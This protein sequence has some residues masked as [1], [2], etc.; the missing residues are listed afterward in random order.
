MSKEQGRYE[1][2][3]AWPIITAIMQ[4]RKIRGKVVVRFEKKE[5]KKEGDSETRGAASFSQQGGGKKLGV[6]Y[7]V[8]EYGECIVDMLSNV[9]G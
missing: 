2:Y 4:S 9:F 3:E 6:P 8:V 5:G 7:R 1:S